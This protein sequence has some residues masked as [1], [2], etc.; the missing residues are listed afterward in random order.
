MFVSTFLLKK[1]LVEYD[2]GQLIQL[3]KQSNSQIGQ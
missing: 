3:Q 2:F 1:N